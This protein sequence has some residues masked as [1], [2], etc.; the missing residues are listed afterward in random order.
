ML[1]DLL[2]VAELVSYKARSLK[3]DLSLI[4]MAQPHHCRILGRELLGC[5]CKEI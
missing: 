4:I 1:I 3:P 5:H 2:K